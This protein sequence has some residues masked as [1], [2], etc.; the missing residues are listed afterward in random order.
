MVSA[1]ILEIKTKGSKSANDYYHYSR[2]IRIYPYVLL[3]LLPV[4]VIHNRN[5][6]VCVG[7]SIHDERDLLH[8]HENKF[9]SQ[10][11]L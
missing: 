6:Q 10:S 11:N 7:Y 8:S 1:A 4:P 3:I 5:F 9:R 2:T